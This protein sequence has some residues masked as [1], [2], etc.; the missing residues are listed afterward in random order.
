MINTALVRQVKS[1]DEL[2]CRLI[3]EWDEKKLDATSVNHSSSSTWAVSFTQT[4][5]YLSGAS[6]GGASLPN[7]SA[8]PVNHFHSRITIEGSTPTFGV[9]Q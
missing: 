5:S 1:A 7:P 6:V 8:Q 3:E 2:L 4:N 9:P